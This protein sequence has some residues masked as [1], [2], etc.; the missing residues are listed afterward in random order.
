MCI[1]DQPCT[2]PRPGI[3]LISPI[4]FIEWNGAIY[5]PFRSGLP[6]GIRGAGP[7]IVASLTVGLPS[8]SRFG[9]LAAAADE[10]ATVTVTVRVSFPVPLLPFARSV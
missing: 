9:A 6:S 8:T 2:F 10:P 4:A 3:S 1:P 7:R 5:S